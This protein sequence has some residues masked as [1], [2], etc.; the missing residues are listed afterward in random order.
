MSTGNTTTRRIRRP[1]LRAWIVLAIA[2]LVLVPGFYALWSYRGREGRQMVLAEAKKR[3]DAN[4][5]YL[6]LSYLNRYLELNP[7]DVD[8]LDMKAKL[9]AESA[10]T[11]YQAIEAIKVHDRV[12]A[13]DPDNPKRQETRRRVA[14][15]C[16]RVSRRA[17]AAELLARDLI[18][19]GDDSAEAHR[20]LAR[21]LE[22]L[23]L[24]GAP[25]ALDE[26]RKE[27][28]IAEKKKPGDVEGGQRLA[29]L[30]RD[31][32]ND[33]RK[34]IQVLD[35]LVEQNKNAPESL[36]AAHLVRSR[37]FLNEK[38]RERAAVEV[39]LAL[40]A[41]P[42]SLEV[43]LAAAETALARGDTATARIHLDAIAPKQREGQ[44]MRIKLIEGLID[45]NEQRP[46]EAIQT[47]RSGLMLTGGNNI[48]LT[49]RLANILLETDRAA[50]AEPLIAQFRRLTGGEEPVPRY[51]YLRAFAL[52]KEHRPAEAIQ[53]LE[54]IRYKV[55]KGLEPFLYNVLGQCHEANRDEAKALAAYRQAA[56]LAGDWNFPWLAI[57]R[58][59][60]ADRP[61]DAIATIE[62][63]LVA[64]PGDPK[65]LTVLATYRFRL[66]AKL[67]PDRRSWT[68]VERSLA[69]AKKVAPSSIELALTQ[70]DV[71]MATGHLDDALGLLQAASRL[72][73]KSVPIW[74]ARA[75]ALNRAGRVAAAL[76]VIDQGLAA[77]GPQASLYATRAGLKYSLGHTIEAR[78]VLLEALDRVPPDQ[79]P[80]V[81]TALSD[82]YVMQKDLIAARKSYEEWAR[83]QP[84]N[85]EPRLALLDLALTAGDEAEIHARAEGLSEIGG[86][87]SPYASLAKIQELMWTPPGTSSDD[88]KQ[89]AR[90]KQAETLIEAVKKNN[91]QWPIGYT[92]AGRLH[93]RRHETEKAIVAY[94]KAVALKG[95]PAALNPLIALLIR[96]KRDDDLE[97]LR[98]S[99]AI[100]PRDIERL[101]V[102]QALRVG[103]KDRAEQ[104]AARLVQGDSQGLDGRVWQTQVL[105]ALGKPKE[106]EEAIRLLTRQRPEEPAPWVQLIMFLVGQKRVPE[107]KDAIEQMRKKAHSDRPDIL[108]AQCYRVVGD[109]G[110]ANA[111]YRDALEHAPNNLAVQRSAIDFYEQTG[112][113]DQ[114][115]ALLRV[116][117]KRDPALGWATRRLAVSLSSHVADR[118]AWDEA[119]RL[120]GPEAKADDVPDDVMTRAQVYARSAQPKDR[121]QAITILK[122]LAADL[123]SATTV[124]ELLAP[125]LFADGRP[126]EALK[127]AE[128]AA[129]D[130]NASTNA[131]LI[132]A[133][134]LLA[135][136]DLDKAE[137]QLKRLAS[138]DPDSLSVAELRARI[139]AAKGESAKAAEGLEQTFARWADTAD[140]LTIGQKMVALLTEL[141]QLDA[142]ERVARRVRKLGPR[143]DRFLAEFLGKHG[144]TDEAASL[145]EETASAGDPRGAALTAL[146]LVRSDDAWL[147][148]ADR[149]LDSARKAQPDSIDLL[150]TQATLRH[151]QGRYKEEI[152]LYETILD[153]KPTNFMFLNNMAWTLSEDMNR[154][155]DGLKRI[156]EALSRVGWQP[157]LLDTRGVILTR[158]GRLD[159][160]IND[161]EAAA[162]A[163]P[164]GSITFHLARAYKKKGRADDF[165][166]ALALLKK[167][168]LRADQLEPSDRKE[169]DEVMKEK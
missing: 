155:E 113:R 64:M 37:F 149:F 95:G 120:I 56:E 89:A 112:Q 166:K 29:A 84:D 92:L 49:W 93:E 91:P 18:R 65:L 12:L 41:D 62:Q 121:R 50:E 68:E 129:R 116:V 98:K 13:H 34:A 153:R 72:N 148:R 147:K 117:L 57:A 66:Q 143:G 6:A 81:W 30:Y 151:L 125:L 144:K 45:L 20:L 126:A 162:E 82:F 63:A 108:W 27:F 152:A 111:C 2:I 22:Q 11:E 123:P 67:A 10:Q 74:L 54:A 167:S 70:A 24:E 15:L 158:L 137:A 69:Q 76:E 94:E 75:N 163:L 1:N 118:A 119:L 42:K 32:L 4:Q 109:L 47:W 139:L 164:A 150:N 154:P 19:R 17:S 102:T 55:D 25:K 53:E 58:M 60:S 71:L 28:E 107:A 44:E 14:E 61:N 138:A 31:K 77:A 134:Y 88:P 128:R 51:R 80:T 130:E 132:Y 38:K 101:A 135:N 96:E 79:K 115:E 78:A 46:D 23:A 114:A 159:E 3:L 165:Q 52:L 48:D 33:P 16:L 161:L 136:K 160:A 140:G 100:L 97:R 36:A 59:Q 87:L 73:P 124:R 85:P 156:D 141:N 26:A 35:R 122:N 9:L 83:L 43:R 7:D 157:N 103:D 110:R 5:P 168:G 131:I 86:P 104:L 106:A 127:Q 146:A 90:L 105:Q 39:E 145:L 40:A 21:A 8:A 133:S 169:W 142:A 99:A